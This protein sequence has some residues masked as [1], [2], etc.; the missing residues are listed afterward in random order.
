MYWLMISTLFFAWVF[1][2]YHSLEECNAAKA[3]A[4]WYASANCVP[5]PKRP[6]HNQHTH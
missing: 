1:G 4:P 2:D 6:E 5:G 3:S